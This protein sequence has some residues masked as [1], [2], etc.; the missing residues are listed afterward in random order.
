M[1]LSDK[2]YTEISKCDKNGATVAL[3]KKDEDNLC[4]QVIHNASES[5]EYMTRCKDE[6]PEQFKKRYESFY[7]RQIKK[8]C[9]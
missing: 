6:L 3:L 4:I 9:K 5:S 8:Y 2:P 7:N 1:N